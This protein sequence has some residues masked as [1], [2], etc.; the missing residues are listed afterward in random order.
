MFSNKLPNYENCMNRVNGARL[1]NHM[2]KCDRKLFHKSSHRLL[3]QFGRIVCNV[4]RRLSF[5]LH[6]MG[7]S[8]LSCCT[9]HVSELVLEYLTIFSYIFGKW[10]QEESNPFISY[11]SKQINMVKHAKFVIMDR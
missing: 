7:F 10:G 5:S 8:V 4:G 11:K 3:C 1:I 6:C 2:M 9:V